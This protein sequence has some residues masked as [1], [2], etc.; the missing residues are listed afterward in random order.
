MTLPAAQIPEPTH[1]GK[2]SN[3]GFGLIGTDRGSRDNVSSSKTLQSHHRT[4][5][6][7]TKPRTREVLGFDR[8]AAEF[9]VSECWWTNR[10]QCSLER[11]V[12][13]Q[14]NSINCRL[15][16]L[17]LAKYLRPATQNS[18]ANCAANCLTPP[19]WRCG[20]HKLST[21]PFS[22]EIGGEGG[23]QAG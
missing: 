18:Q 22:P 1:C 4:S 14:K 5:L 10:Q 21:G 19:D 11:L 17:V 9:R 2:H 15:L 3:G 13:A 6:L 12:I 16:T 8:L 7:H 20:D 23:R